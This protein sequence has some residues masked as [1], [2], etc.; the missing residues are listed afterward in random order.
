MVALE[1]RERERP[2]PDDQVFPPQPI[3]CPDRVVFR[4]YQHRRID[5]ANRDACH[6]IQA[7][8]RLFV[9]G[10]DGPIFVGPQCAS[11]LQE[12]SSAF[13]FHV[14]PPSSERAIPI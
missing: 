1:Q 14:N 12:E 9:Q 11:S 10:F 2:S 6:D 7:E 4:A 3:Q 13:R 8:T 5:R